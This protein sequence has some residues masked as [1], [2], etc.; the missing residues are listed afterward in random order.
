[1]GKRT[2]VGVR[3]GAQAGVFKVIEGFR[4]DGNRFRSKP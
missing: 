4:G 1:L 3:K 2:A